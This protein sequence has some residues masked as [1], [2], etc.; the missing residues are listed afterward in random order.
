MGLSE[1]FRVFPFFFVDIRSCTQEQ[2]IEFCILCGCDYLP[3]VARI[4]PKTAAQV[5]QKEGS[6]KA[7]VACLRAGKG[8]KGCT[9]LDLTLRR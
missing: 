6:L 4:G 5:L 9:S 2:F 3:H 8:P 7:A 1:S